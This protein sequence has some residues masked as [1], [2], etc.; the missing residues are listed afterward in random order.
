MLTLKSASKFLLFTLGAAS[1]KSNRQEKTVDAVV[2]VVVV[3]ASGCLSAN[4]PQ[5]KSAATDWGFIHKWM[6][7]SWCSV[8]AQEAAISGSI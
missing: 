1:L 5:K 2:V 6:A 4:K 8:I 3:V 7:T